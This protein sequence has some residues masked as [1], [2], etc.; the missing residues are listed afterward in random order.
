MNGSLVRC[1]TD[2]MDISLA[3]SLVSWLFVWLIG[4]MDGKMDGWL[5]VS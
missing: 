1:S 2:C 3:G 5:F 4:W